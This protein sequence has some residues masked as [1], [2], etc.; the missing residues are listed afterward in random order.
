MKSLMAVCMAIHMALFGVWVNPA[1]VYKGGISVEFGKTAAAFGEA[2]PFTVSGRT[3]VPIREVFEALGFGINWDDATQSV[4]LSDDN[5]EIRIPIGMQK[6]SINGIIYNLEV[7]AQLVNEKAKLPMDILLDGIGNPLGWDDKTRTF[8]ASISAHWINRQ[9][10]RVNRLPEVPVF[11]AAGAILIDFESGNE[12]FAHN[13]DVLRPPASM[14]KMMTVYLVYEA[15]YNG[16]ICFG[17]I[18][19]ISDYALEWSRKP[20]E[21]NVPLTQTR[22]YT[23][24]DLLDAVVIVSAGGATIAL[25]ELLG[26]TVW[27][28][29]V[30]MNQKADEWDLGMSFGHPS[31]GGRDTMTPRGMAILTRNAIARFPEML[32][33][34]STQSGYFKGRRINS[35]N[36]LLGEFYGMDGFK[37]GTNNSARE[38]FSGT[39]KRDGVRL[40]VVVMGSN[41]GQRFV[42]TRVLLEY[43]FAYMAIL[44]GSNE[45][46][47]EGR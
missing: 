20:H 24:D 16:I 45:M 44:R 25:A 27:G 19:P 22:R 15:V 13:A 38:N 42:D 10:A 18:V 5:H 30:M 2:S 36:R 26:R 32:E 9:T 14:N 21:S 8:L 39:A 1:T 3:P 37:T 35:T 17:T 29:T 47:S 33:R 41:W 6:F 7:A 23:V 34:T 40:I 11:S 46:T 43:G 4:I 28:F 31:G 12:I